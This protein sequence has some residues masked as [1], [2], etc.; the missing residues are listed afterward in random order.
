MTWDADSTIYETPFFS[1]VR[2]QRAGKAPGRRHFVIRPHEDSVIILVACGSDVLLVRSERLAVKAAGWE[3]PAGGIQPG[4]TLQKAAEREL[5]QE[6]G[7]VADGLTLV[8]SYCPMVSRMDVRFHL[9][10]QALTA[11]ARPPV[12]PADGECL[13]ARWVQR[14][15]LPDLVARGE[16]IDVATLLGLCWVGLLRPWE[17][18]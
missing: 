7:L 14:E 5:M 18:S 12:E 10:T 15:T 13:D 1:V 11:A 3:M 17:V 2:R 4:K 16:I 6:T 9:F 8:L